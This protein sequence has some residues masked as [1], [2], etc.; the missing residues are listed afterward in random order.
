MA[1][2]S[3]IVATIKVRAGDSPRNTAEFSFPVHGW[4]GG[5]IPD[6][7][8]LGADIQ[9]T[10]SSTVQF[11]R[12]GRAAAEHT[13]NLM[14]LTGSAV[15]R[16]LLKSFIEMLQMSRATIT[17]EWGQE[18]VCIIRQARVTRIKYGF[19]KDGA[20]W[21]IHYTLTLRSITDRMLKL[22]E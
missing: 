22:N 6:A 12:T 2:T 9:R 19:G 13:I 18:H 10:G 20:V 4:E 1:I 16:N 8:E 5:P 3:P 11:Q 7:A 17:D 21:R 14:T 15:T